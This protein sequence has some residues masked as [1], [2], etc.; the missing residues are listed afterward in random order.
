MLP[1][2]LCAAVVWAVQPAAFAQTPAAPAAA[3]SA[4]QTLLD[5]ARAAIRRKDFAAA[6]APLD[7]QLAQKPDDAAAHFL[8]GRALQELKRW[9]EAIT[10]YQRAA[11]LAPKS[12]AAWANLCWTQILANQALAARPACES[13]LALNEGGWV[14]RVNL[15]HTWLLAGDATNAQ[16]HYRDVLWRIQTEAQLQAGPLADFDVFIAKGWQ[17]EAARVAKSWFQK[18]WP[19]MFKAA[20]LNVKDTARQT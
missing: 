19:R 4:P 1:L 18:Q 9:D 16:H 7:Q 13:A 14:A 12:S 20:E 6:L 15:G 10:P 11:Q 2:L 5:E 8:R 17:P 3:A